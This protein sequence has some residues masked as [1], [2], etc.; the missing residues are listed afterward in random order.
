M[1]Y[2]SKCFKLAF[3][4]IVK[5]PNICMFQFMFFCFG[6]WTRMRSE[7]IEVYFPVRRC[8]LPLARVHKVLLICLMTYNQRYSRILTTQAS[9]IYVRSRT[10]I[11]NFKVTRCII[12][13]PFHWSS[14]WEGWEKTRGL[15]EK[16]LGFALIRS[17][18][19]LEAKKNLLM[20]LLF[21]IPQASLE[22]ADKSWFRTESISVHHE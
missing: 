3:T 20:W 13:A 9:E 10:S 16:N 17:S 2:C 22:W 21:D 1:V 7:N 14:P 6:I 5:G 19:F 18:H 4:G 8:N 15:E 11:Y 12:L